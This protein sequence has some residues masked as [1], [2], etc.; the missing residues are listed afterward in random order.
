VYIFQHFILFFKISSLKSLKNSVSLRTLGLVKSSRFRN[1]PTNMG[2]VL[3]EDYKL[4]KDIREN[5]DN[6]E[7]T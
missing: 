2:K 6:W 4:K 1:D 3:Y 5:F 7:E